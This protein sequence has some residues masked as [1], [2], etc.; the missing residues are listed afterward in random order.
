MSIWTFL[1]MISRQRLPR[2]WTAIEWRARQSTSPYDNGSN[3]NCG[4]DGRVSS[5]DCCRGG[6]GTG[7]RAD[8]QNKAGLLPDAMEGVETAQ[9]MQVHHAPLPLHP[10]SRIATIHTKSHLEG[11][12]LLH[13][14]RRP[15][16]TCRPTNLPPVLN[17]IIQLNQQYQLRLPPIATHILPQAGIIP[18]VASVNLHLYC[19]CLLHA[20]PIACF[21]LET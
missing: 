10:I 5:N 21:L 7:D 8:L 15:T 6:E 20:S 16:R 12:L 2:R 19:I 13:Q 11:W 17:Q 18:A 4:G 14:I 9:E 3:A 1:R